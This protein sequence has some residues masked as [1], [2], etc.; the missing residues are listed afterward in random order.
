MTVQID[1]RT[2]DADMLETLLDDAL[3]AGV[4]DYVWQIIGE[5]ERREGRDEIII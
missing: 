5:I 2:L 1:F 4:S 3:L